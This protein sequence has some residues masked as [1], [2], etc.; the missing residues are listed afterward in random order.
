MSIA[1]MAGLGLMKDKFRI[2]GSQGS[3]VSGSITGS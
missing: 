3:N 1:N 2:T